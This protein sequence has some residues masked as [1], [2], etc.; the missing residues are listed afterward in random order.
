MPLVRRDPAG[1]TP[2]VSDGIPGRPEELGAAL[3]TA[4]DLRARESILATLV[5]I[6][7]AAAAAALAGHLSSEDAGLR[8]ACIETLQAIPG[9]ALSVLPDLLADPDPDVRL[10]AT[11]IVRT[12]PAETANGLLAHLIHGE[13]HPNVVGAAVEV[14]AEVGTAEAVPALTAARARFADQAFLSMAIDTVLARIGS[15]R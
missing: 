10:L 7:D 8:N 3:A 14:L 9:P 15:G 12:Q 1:S 2:K 5:A 11:E 13:N 6:A 4:R